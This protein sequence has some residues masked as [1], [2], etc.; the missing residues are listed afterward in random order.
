MSCSLNIRTLEF[1]NFFLT[2]S[3]GFGNKLFRNGKVISDNSWHNLSLQ[4]LNDFRQTF[5]SFH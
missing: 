1:I 4:V 2:H 5:E 3:Q